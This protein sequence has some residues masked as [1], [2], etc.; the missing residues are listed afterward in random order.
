M[1]YVSMKAP[2]FAEVRL[3]GTNFV[4]SFYRATAYETEADAMAAFEKAKKFLPKKSL[5]KFVK[6][7]AV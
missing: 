6:V 5:A 4:L 1:F 3:R 7:I 2:G